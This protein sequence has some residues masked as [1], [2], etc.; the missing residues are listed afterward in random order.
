MP[1]IVTEL[2][3]DR[4]QTIESS[5]K[6]SS[7]ELFYLVQDV[8]LESEVITINGVTHPATTE[9]FALQAVRDDCP[10]SIYGM[11]RKELRISA[12]IDDTSYKVAVSYAYSGTSYI[13]REDDDA[14]AG[15]RT[16]TFSSAA[17]TRH[18]THSHETIERIGN[19]PDESGAIN[20][21]A[22]HNIHGVEILS[23]SLSFSETHY[24]TYKKFKISYIRDLHALMG[25]VNAKAFRGF[26]AGEV[27]FDGFNSTRRGT[28]RDDLY[29]VT[30]HFAVIPNQPAQRIHGLSIPK[31]DGWDYLWLRT[32]KKENGGQSP[33]GTSGGQGAGE[34]AY[35][36]VT[37]AVEGA[38]IERIYHRGDFGRLKIKT[39]P[40][41]P[42]GEPEKE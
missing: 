36:S 4:T 17:G 34:A 3:A 9:Y 22:D 30:F 16:I 1:P 8:T 27:R 24:F 21:D 10:K 42:I 39:A 12:K 28:K 33:D 6:Y 32:R 37:S 14:D 2:F 19:A 38:Y 40:F 20:V 11:A 18:I 15:D 25:C 5:G 7:L 26:A 13:G 23:P 35:G 29:E 41:V 31:K